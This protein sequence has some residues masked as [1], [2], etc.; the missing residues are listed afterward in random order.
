[1]SSALSIWEKTNGADVD[2]TV[3]GLLHSLMM[4]SG[5]KN[6]REGE[7]QTTNNRIRRHKQWCLG[8]LRNVVQQMRQIRQKFGSILANLTTPYHAMPFNTISLPD[9]R[10]RLPPL[11]KQCQAVVGR[12]VKRKHVGE[13]VSACSV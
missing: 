6:E 4:A 2:S 9:L 7:T 13:D 8:F 12:G 5:F 3:P 1:M 11:P 10:V